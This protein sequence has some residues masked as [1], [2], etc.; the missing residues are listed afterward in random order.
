MARTGILFAQIAQAAMKVVEQGKNPT[1]DNVREALGGT[2]SKSTIAPLL[3]RWKEEQ[4]GAIVPVEPGVPP[5]LLHAVKGVY[6]RMQDDVHAQLEQARQTHQAEILSANER[7]QQQQLENIALLNDRAALAAALERATVTIERLQT[8]NQSLNLSLATAHSD[9]TGMQQRLCD[10]ADEVNALNAQL[11]QARTQFE[12][13]HESIAAQ[14]AQERQFAEQRIARLEQE[15]SNVRQQLSQQQTTV[16]QQAGQ[17]AQ[18]KAEN[19]RAHEA[20]HLAQEDIVTLR[21]EQEKLLY[22]L[23]ETST[24]RDAIQIAHE[25]THHELIAAGTQLAVQVKQNEMLLERL[26]QVEGRFDAATREKNTLLQH[27]A[28]L[29]AELAQTKQR[30][31]PTS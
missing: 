1:V 26:A 21:V 2:G 5:T 10:R 11:S 6:E 4:Q 20:V 16:A 31:D 14:R 28:M 9:V 23:K 22:Q 12:H 19:K 17:L 3:K 7:I 25:K 30:N 27:Q 15:L 8:E 24:A 29:Q 18:L 13:Y